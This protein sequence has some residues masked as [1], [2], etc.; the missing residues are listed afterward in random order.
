MWLDVVLVGCSGCGG[1]RGSGGGG[2]NVVAMTMVVGSRWWQLV[3]FYTIH[4]TT[5]FFDTYKTTSPFVK[6]NNT[7][8]AHCSNT[9]VFC[10]HPLQ[11][12]SF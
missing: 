4:K 3:S 6:A 1:I 5:L 7:S 8:N 11:L 9:S 2:V 10:Q 12:P